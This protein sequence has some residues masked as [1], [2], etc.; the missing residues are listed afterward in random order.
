MPAPGFHP[1][2]SL[3]QHTACRRAISAAPYVRLEHSDRQEVVAR[4]LSCG[5]CTSVRPACVCHGEPA[6]DGQTGVHSRVW[7]SCCSQG[8]SYNHAFTVRADA[9]V[10]AGG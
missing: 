8:L 9:R 2:A 3:T 6:L 7:G 10:F 4:C 5:H 1:R